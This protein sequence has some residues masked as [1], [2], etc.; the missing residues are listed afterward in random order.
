MI[1]AIEVDGPVWIKRRAVLPSRTDEVIRRHRHWCSEDS[2]RRRYRQGCRPEVVQEGLAEGDRT[3][4]NFNRHFG[5]R[6]LRHLRGHAGPS[7]DKHLHE[8]VADEN[9][10]DRARQLK[11]Y[12]EPALGFEITTCSTGGTNNVIT[13]KLDNSLNHLGE[14]GYQLDISSDIIYLVAFR[15]KGI[16]WGIQTL[17]QLLPS[18]IL[19]GVKVNRIAWKVPCMKVSDKPRFKW[20]GLMLD[21]SRTFITKEQ[22]KKYLEALSFFKMNVLHLHLTDDQGWRIEIKKYPELTAVSSKF[23]KSY[24]E[25]KEFEGYYSQ[26]DL[27][28]LIEFAS[29]RNIEIVPEIE[30][31]GHSYEVFAAFPKLSCKGDTAKI[32][33][34]SKGIDIHNEIFCAGNEETF[35][36]IQHVLDEITT[37]FPSQYVHIG[38]DEAPKLYWKECSKC[39]K[40]IKDEGL[41][42]ENELQSWFVKRIENYLN[43]KKKKLIGWDE[44]TQ[45]GLSRSAT[46]M[47]W[48]GWEKELPLHIAELGNNLIMTPNSHCYFDYTNEK[49]STEMVYSFNPVPKEL[50]TEQ[51]KNILGV[52]A[53]FWSHIDRTPHLIDRQLFPRLLALSEIAWTD[54][55]QK[56]WNGFKARMQIKLKSLDILGVS[57]FSEN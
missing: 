33:P 21:C 55:D 20:R 8:I 16:F 29:Q 10:R 19:R 4:P 7:V 28:E 34:Y 53:N 12:L 44:I 27:K 49:I 40:R 56:E 39:Q 51:D 15:E 14:E 11:S 17:R 6:L 41:K 22:I 24:N 3:T 36:F 48:R 26:D 43:S 37:L 25:P 38:G 2:W 35:N 57:Y 31:P 45:G 47:Y 54:Y 13:L 46:V 18:E 9:L 1:P 32:H 23:H 5:T 50:T 42:D 30:M 52:Q